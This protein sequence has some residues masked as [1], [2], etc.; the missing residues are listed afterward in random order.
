[1]ALQSPQLCGKGGG[2][3]GLDL[4]ALKGSIPHELSEGSL[5]PGPLR[6]QTPGRKEHRG[7]CLRKGEFGGKF[8][9]PP[10]PPLLPSHLTHHRLS[11]HLLHARHSGPRPPPR[12][13]PLSLPGSRLDIVNDSHSTEED[14][15]DQRGSLV[16][17][18]LRAACPNSIT[19]SSFL[20][21]ISLRS[22]PQSHS[23]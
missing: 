23:V 15:E 14:T 19:E 13:S 11:P 22:H 12:L 3:A 1:M 21:C 18:K 10:P 2:G 9:E 20:H 16:N 7:Q 4:P 17:S 5:S 8:G 6:N